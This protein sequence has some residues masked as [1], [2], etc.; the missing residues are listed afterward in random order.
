MARLCCKIPP[1]SVLDETPELIVPQRILE[2][3]LGRTELN[4]PQQYLQ[5]Y[6]S[7]LNI[8]IEIGKMHLHVSLS[9]TKQSVIC[10]MYQQVA[11]GHMMLSFSH[12]LTGQVNLRSFLPT[13]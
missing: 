1:G 3:L 7:P 5:M 9:I 12:C 10:L 4:S 11:Q 6:N 2:K 13:V 8:S